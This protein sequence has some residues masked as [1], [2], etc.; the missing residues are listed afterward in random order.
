[1]GENAWVPI[2]AL[3]ARLIRLLADEPRIG[4]LEASR[5]L[6]VARGTVQAR[7]DRLVQSGVI[8]GFGPELDPAA[9]GYTVMAF[10]TLQ[11][12]QGRGQSVATHLAGI[13]EVLEVHTIT[14]DADMLA[15]IVAR[16]H[17][18]LQ[19]VIDRLVAHPDIVRTS[20]NIA[21]TAHI[22][23]RTDGLLRP[24]TDGTTD[25]PNG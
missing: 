25:Q 17:E 16:S 1:M 11:I 12:S 6:R 20:T 14:G 3:D 23:H 19:R 18:D 21:L 2:D 22:R 10:A 7:L 4:V 9:L 5:R 8:V 13:D 24:F 15:R